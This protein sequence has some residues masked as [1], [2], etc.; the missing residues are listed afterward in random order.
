MTSGDREILN[1]YNSGAT[2]QAFNLIVKNYKER[3]YWHL[4]HFVCSHEDADDLLQEVFIKVWNGLPGFREDSKLITWLYKIATNEALNF[5]R[6][7][8]VQFFLSMSSLEDNLVRKIED[9]PY[10]NGNELQR[11][12]WK[13]IQKL[14]DKQKAVF[15]LRY[16]DD[17]SYEEI[18]RILDTSV[19]S[20]KASYH[21]AYI[22]IKTD[23]EKNF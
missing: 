10:F 1:L 22:K 13:A 21:H 4:R 9:D 12:L 14:P 15:M 6:K 3:L 23:L 5:L 2:E 20:L 17:L 19:G 7:K 11:E 18:S 8:K 16:F